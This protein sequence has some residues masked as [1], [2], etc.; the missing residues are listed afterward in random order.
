MY[1]PLWKCRPALQVPIASELRNVN[2][3]TTV[4]TKLQ[5]LVIS[6]A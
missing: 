4:M 6:L 5:I 3:T 2:V 1:K